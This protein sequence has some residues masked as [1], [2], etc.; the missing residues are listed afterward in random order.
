MLAGQAA[1]LTG[2]GAVKLPLRREWRRR[3]ASDSVQLGAAFMGLA[4]SL[5][6]R[7]REWQTHLAALDDGIRVPHTAPVV[8]IVVAA[9]LVICT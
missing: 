9:R 4:P 7:P 1:G 6:S 8:G 3:E 5:G 2:Q